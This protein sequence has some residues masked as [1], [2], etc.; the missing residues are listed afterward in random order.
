MYHIV[1][2]YDQEHR[3]RF[4]SLFLRGF[5]RELLFELEQLYRENIRGI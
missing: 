5:S 2:R 3:F 4:F 1:E